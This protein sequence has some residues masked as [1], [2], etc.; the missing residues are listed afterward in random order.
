M[1]VPRRCD[2][3]PGSTAFISRTAA[4]RLVSNWSLSSSTEY[5]F[6]GR[7]ETIPCVVNQNVDGAILV[8]EL[9]QDLPHLYVVI[10]IQLNDRHLLSSR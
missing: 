5:F 10:D 6:H 9:R 7:P 8:H 1:M 3:M 4:N 2:I